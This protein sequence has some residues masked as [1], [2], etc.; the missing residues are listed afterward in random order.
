[1]GKFS[2]YFKRQEA[3]IHG[4]TKG[5]I[6]DGGEGIKP[7][8]SVY[9]CL[10]MDFNAGYDSPRPPYSLLKSLASSLPSG[11][12]IVKSIYKTYFDANNKKQECLLVSA[13]N[14]SLASSKLKLFISHFYSAEEKADNSLIYNCVSIT[15]ASRTGNIV[16]CNA[17]NTYAAGDIV[18]IYYVEGEMKSDLNRKNFEIISRTGTYFTIEAPGTGTS[19]TGTAYANY[20]GFFE[21]FTELTEYYKNGEESIVFNSSDYYIG[22]NQ[23]NLRA[24]IP[25]KSSNF[26][27]AYKGFHVFNEDTGMIGMV[28]S[29][30]SVLVN[31]YYMQE[32]TFAASY[33][34]HTAWG[35]F[36]GRYTGDAYTGDYLR[37]YI[38]LT[39]KTDLGSGIYR[40]KF[41]WYIINS[42]GTTLNTGVLLE[43][44]YSSGDTVSYNG[45]INDSGIRA[46]FSDL[47]SNFEGGD[48]YQV[49]VYKA[50]VSQVFMNYEGNDLNNNVGIC[51]FRVNYDNR[52]NWNKITSVKYNNEFANVLRINCGDSSRILWLGFLKQREH[53]GAFINDTITYNN[54]HTGW[55]NIPGSALGGSYKG[56][57]EIKYYLKCSYKATDG[58]TYWD[59]Q[60]QWW[61]NKDATV[62]TTPLIHAGT[63]LVGVY[64][65][66]INI[67]LNPQGNFSDYTVGDI[68]TVPII[69]SPYNKLWNG[70]YLDYDMPE[71]L[72]K[73][74]YN[75]NDGQVTQVNIEEKSISNELGLAYRVSK[76]SESGL[77]NSYRIYSLCIEIDGYQTIFIKNC[78]TKDKYLND[79]YGYIKPYFNR[80]ITA[81]ILF[82]SDYEN[83]SILE[84]N[85]LP[86]SAK[87]CNESTP[88]INRMNKLRIS[89]YNGEMSFQVINDNIIGSKSLS[90]IAADGITMG[91]YLNY[92]Y[93][94]S[95]ICVAKGSIKVGKQ[96]IAYNLSQDIINADLNQRQVNTGKCCI[97][98]SSYQNSDGEPETQS[99]FASENIKEITGD[100]ILGAASLPENQ[101]LIF[102]KKDCHWYKLVTLTNG[103]QSLAALG[104]FYNYGLVNSNAFVSASFIDS[105]LQGT[106]SW[107]VGARDFGGV[108]FASQD[109]IYSFYKNQMIDLLEGRNKIEYKN[110]S[111]NIKSAI[112]AGYYPNT[113]EIYFKI[114]SNIHIFNLSANHWKIHSYSAT[115]KDFNYVETGQLIFNDL[116]KIYILEKEGSTAYLDE[117]TLKISYK[118]VKV[119]NFNDNSIHKIPAGIDFT[120][121]ELVPVQNGGEDLL[122]DIKINI[123]SALNTTD[124]LTN[125]VVNLNSKSKFTINTKIKKRCNF[126]VVTIENS[127]NNNFKR[128]KFNEIIIRALLT[129]KKF[130]KI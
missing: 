35:S 72:N 123:G 34:S 103:E 31:E 58:S 3:L 10:N 29:S 36:T 111:D 47:C 28:I 107:E 77:T 33:G 97:A 19:I 32:K 25:I 56:E 75:Y 57:D 67:T 118:W 73:K 66:V 26:I 79:I 115:A 12:S 45:I 95:V 85:I 37:F 80:R 114:N 71:V 70:F 81:H 53:F 94:N 127:T 88:G 41:E 69:K 46:I 51:R 60:F 109:S 23:Y 84:S 122:C 101:F 99:I 20:V 7:I 42:I 65:N 119:L 5:R 30:F 24:N 39:S 105:S 13:K 112:F 8:E 116:T 117:G 63:T 87:L 106:A 86:S 74:S 92:Y 18:H 43:D 90:E 120:N 44:D 16:T 124:I 96:I 62:Y 110:L 104:T 21:D 59:L 27:N 100:E 48:S 83:L 1:M 113:K 64:V 128:I 93:Y 15:S 40:L 54:T 82:Y 89:D 17:V 126:F 125:K 6:T 11:Y 9:D 130:N 14:L 121:Y 76:Q 52:N 50:S 129:A 55:C 4:N 49:K 98:I 2:K 91:S 102:T 78:F 38:S 61:T 22:D 108:Y 68:A